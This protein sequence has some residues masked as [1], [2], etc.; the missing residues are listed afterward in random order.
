MPTAPHLSRRDSWPPTIIS[1]AST[2]ASCPPP[3]I[4]YT[5]PASRYQ[6]SSDMMDI[7]ENPFSY[8][9]ETPS[10]DDYDDSLDLSAGI[11]GSTTPPRPEVREVS[12][13]S[14]MGRRDEKVQAEEGTRLKRERVREQQEEEAGRWLGVGAP[15]SL[16]DFTDRQSKKRRASGPS[17]PSTSTAVQRGRGVVRLT[18]SKRGNGRVRSRSLSG[19][20]R[21]SWRE[22]SPEIVSIPEGDEIDTFMGEYREQTPDLLSDNGMSEMDEFQEPEIVRKKAKIGKEK[23]RVRW[24]MPERCD[25]DD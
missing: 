22:P 9:L 5:R 21:R 7:D 24:A 14:L 19:P 13:S 17:S 6:P 20:R 1:L 10:M 3:A 25:I 2:D 15:L 23:K 4:T 11:E 8:F 12:P 18:P 16:R